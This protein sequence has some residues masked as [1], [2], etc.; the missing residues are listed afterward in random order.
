MNLFLGL[1]WL[2]FSVA[3]F[4]YESG[5]G[6]RPLTVAGM[7]LS[8]GWLFL[9]LAAWNLVRW[10]SSQAQRNNRELLQDLESRRSRSRRRRDEELAGPSILEDAP[11]EGEPPNPPAK[12]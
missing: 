10:Y 11:K 1:F 4:V 6:R 7:N 9:M 2:A 3:I 12:S 8:A 5:T